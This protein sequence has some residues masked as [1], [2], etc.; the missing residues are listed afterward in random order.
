M[1]NHS[2]LTIARKRNGLT[3]TA[4]ATA[5]QKSPRTISAYEAGKL[6]PQPEVL[7]R[8][9]R[10]LGFPVAF[11]SGEDLDTPLATAVSF[12]ALSKMSA[13]ERDRA[14]SQGAL[15][16]ELNAWIEQRF[17]LPPAQLPDLSQ[18]TDPEAAAASLRQL[19]GL[20]ESPVKNMIHLLEAKG[21]RVYSLAVDSL[22]VDAYSYWHDETPMIF[23]NTGKSA[24]RGRYDAAHELG[25]LI[26]HRHARKEDIR[27]AESDANKFASSFLM[28]RAGTIARA[29]RF[30]TVQELI[31]RKKF[32]VV[33]VAALNHRLH[34]LGITN[35]WQY[36]HLSTEISKLRYRTEEPD[37]APREA[38]QLLQKVLSVLRNDSLSLRDIAESL[39]YPLSELQQLIFGLTIT[40]LEGGAKTGSARF[41]SGAQLTLI[42]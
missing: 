7:E 32:W 5:L 2:R 1:Y 22:N 41:I 21:V 3:M 6:E 42:P 27:L 16:L 15:A 4:L 24:E 36:R 38:S 13:I 18:E 25:H 29:P 31:R 12:R 35:D 34:E 10:T 11:F 20:G 28:P 23:L 17:D 39:N 33:S 30:V 9:A 8:I 40:S 14:L 19:W 26:L 37:P